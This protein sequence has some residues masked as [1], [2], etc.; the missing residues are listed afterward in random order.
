[1]VNY[2]KLRGR[3]DLEEDL[4]LEDKQ[5]SLLIAVNGKKIGCESGHLLREP[6]LLRS[7]DALGWR[8]SNLAAR[9]NFMRHPKNH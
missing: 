8:F 1:M 2:E 5:L 6:N 7:H 4:V 3:L 9:W